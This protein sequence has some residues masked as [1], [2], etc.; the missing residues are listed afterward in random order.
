MSKPYVQPTNI[1]EYMRAFTDNSKVKGFG[2]DTTMHTPCP[3]CAA[4]DFHVFKITQT[5]QEL[6]KERVCTQ[7]GR[8]MTVV[9]STSD[10]GSSKRFSF[11]QTSGPDQPE[12][13]EPK[14]P[15][16]HKDPVVKAA[17]PVASNFI[18][19]AHRHIGRKPLEPIAYALRGIDSVR[20]CNWCGSVHPEDLAAWIRAGLKLEMADMKYGW[21]HKFYAVAGTT[22]PTAPTWLKFYTE[23]LLDASPADRDTIEREIGLRIVFSD[24]KGGTVSWH[25]IMPGE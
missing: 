16:A 15:R 17:S 14:M 23:H 5:E 24:D 13:L 7:C 8:G 2:F 21:P 18:T 20:T 22:P 25:P 9:T 6:D 12:W 1:D 3:F 11:Y 19:V 4:P 10:S